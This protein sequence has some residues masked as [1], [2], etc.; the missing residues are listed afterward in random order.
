M[1][2]TDAIEQILSAP[3]VRELGLDD[4]ALDEVLAHASQNRFFARSGAGAVAVAAESL[5]CPSLGLLSLRGIFGARRQRTRP[6]ARVCRA[7]AG[8][9]S[10]LPK[11][12]T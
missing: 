3:G 7:A 11:S 4:R 12:N 6:A 8:Y 5:R 9:K 2:S 10:C 1:I